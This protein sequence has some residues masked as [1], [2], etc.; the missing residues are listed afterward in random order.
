MDVHATLLA[1][2]LRAETRRRAF[3]RKVFSRLLAAVRAGPT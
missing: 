1:K 2:A 3:W